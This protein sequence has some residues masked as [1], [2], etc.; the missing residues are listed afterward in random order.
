M[1]KL[2]ASIFGL[3]LLS[4][5]LFTGVYYWWSIQLQAAQPG[6]T[7][8]ITFT[9][10]PNQTAVQTINQLTNNHLIKSPLAA[11]LYLQFT[12]QDQKIRPGSYTLSPNQDL[13]SIF[14]ALVSGPK[15][16]KVT[17]PEGWRREQVAAR[18]SSVL[19]AFD[20]SE[21]LLL[22]ASLEGRL[23]PDTYFIPPSASP[24]QIVSIFT[25]NFAK[26]SGLNLPAQNNILILASLVER[27]ARSD[28]DRAIIAGI[29]QKRL[30]A[31]WPLQ[32]DATVQYA[33]GT[34]R[35]WWSKNIDT[36]FP[37]PYNTYLNVGL[38][39]AP[40]ASP[41]LASI[42]AAL[43]P[44]DSPYWYYLTGN[45]GQMYYAPDLPKHNLNIDRYLSL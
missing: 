38:P 32:V 16:I 10:A 12:G 24:S 20:S 41:G 5:A 15:D 45:D 6:S 27:E 25:A 26:K 9:V 3:L 4:L 28:P 1:N 34:S 22:T 36:K 37:S 43:S 18:L 17:F 39:P 30:E 29:F 2:L 35:E 19:P 11:K 33:L 14:K 42:R 23:F 40:I 44:Q 31:G 21:F 7:Q 13:S 8:E